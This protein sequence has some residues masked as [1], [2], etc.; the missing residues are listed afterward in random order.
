MCVIIV[1]KAGADM[2][3]LNVLRA[4]HKA[5]P[6]GCGL[7][8]GKKTIKTLDFDE[9]LEECDKV[10]KNEPCILH[11][12][13]ATHGSVRT[14]NCHPFTQGDVVFAHNGILDIQPKG[15]LTDSETA[16]K[17]RLMPV[18]TKYGYG[19]REMDEAVH[20]VIGMSKFAFIKG[21]RVRTYGRY[22]ESD[23]LLF[24]NLN[25][26]WAMRSHRFS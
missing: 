9:F 26:L 11:F 19:S 20:K 25:F 15:D 16:F 22:I 21:R 17:F 24:S 8:T 3:S 2:P 6:H 7:T 5:N 13:Y 1:K 14:E 23:G 10:K 12:R 18:I 4:A